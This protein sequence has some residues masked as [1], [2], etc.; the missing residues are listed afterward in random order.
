MSAFN[1]VR[2]R[3]KP[4]RQDEFIAAHR[5]W[6]E[7]FPG[8]KKFSLIKTGDRTFCIVGE[9]SGMAALV[10]ARP[11][12]IAILDNFRDL[13]EDQGNGLGVTDPVSGEA[14]LERS[15]ARA[16]GQKKPAAKKPA[17]KSARNTVRR[18]ARKR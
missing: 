15:F 7:K 12:M 16:A 5:A 9:W 17:A 8:M 1:V 4:G 2:F 10:R 6:R 18:P 14:V 11:K 3:V 13:L